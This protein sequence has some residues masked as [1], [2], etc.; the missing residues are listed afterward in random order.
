MSETSLETQR[1]E[2]S[3][4]A[5]GQG[6]R[7]EIDSRAQDAGRQARSFADALR[8]SG[9]Q[10]D[11]SAV[12]KV[13]DAVAGQIDRAGSYL[14][15]AQTDRV[16]GDAESMARRRPWAVAGAAAIVGFAAS[17]LLKTS[18][19]QRY[20]STRRDER[21]TSWEPGTYGTTRPMQADAG[22]PGYAGER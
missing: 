3:H 20:G 19:E 6:L 7:N 22:A 18:S 8:E 1:R 14:E 4:E 13:A 16:L 12:G 10:Q 17:R 5:S 11:G 15:H 9:R 2:T 21:E